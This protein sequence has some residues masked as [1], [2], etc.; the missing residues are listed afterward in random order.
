MKMEVYLTQCTSCLLLILILS[1]VSLAQT[2]ETTTTAAAEEFN[3]LPWY[4]WLGIALAFSITVILIGS[5][6]I[7]IV[8]SCCR[9]CKQRHRDERVA[10]PMQ[11]SPGYPKQVVQDEVDAFQGSMNMTDDWE[12]ARKQIKLVKQ[13][14]I[15]EYGPI[16]EA[17]V[18]LKTNVTVRSLV[19]VFQQGTSQDLVRFREDIDELMAFDHQ[20]IGKLLGMV[21][22]C[23]Y[24]IVLEMTVNGDLKSFLLA[25]SA[26]GS[27]TKENG[28]LR[29]GQA[30][31]TT[32]QRVAMATDAACGLAY[33]EGLQY[34]HRDVA[35]RNCMVTQHLGIKIGDYRVGRYLFRSEYAVQVDGSLMPLRWMAPESMLNNIFTVQSSVW[36]LGVLLWEV[37]SEGSFPYPE[38]SDSN[39]ITG[40]CYE[41]RRLPR[42]QYC[43][44]QI[45]SLM[46]RC[47]HDNPKQRPRPSVVYKTLETS[48]L[49]NRYQHS[50]NTGDAQLFY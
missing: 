4:Y 28:R 24:Y 38:L 43:P 44:E 47:W 26:A 21:S 39:V 48:I 13:L 33:L 36:S 12:L 6:A 11:R 7:C 30:E 37:M 22:Q 42:P 14:G 19:K 23:P 49:T 16:Y 9:Y 29:L 1:H 35:A 45:Y 20:S 3:N 17:E 2:D 32:P 34:A 50:E 46:K 41:G 40:V 31:L 25:T 8:Y 5:S 27:T 10:L 15:G 18:K